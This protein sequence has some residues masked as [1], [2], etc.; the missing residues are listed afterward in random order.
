MQAKQVNMRVTVFEVLLHSVRKMKSLIKTREADK[1]QPEFLLMGA[2]CYFL[3]I[4][5]Q[6][7]FM[8]IN[9]LYGFKEI[10]KNCFNI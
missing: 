7:Q 1:K 4:T 6:I 10:F 3:C 5:S 9:L 8:T 2:T